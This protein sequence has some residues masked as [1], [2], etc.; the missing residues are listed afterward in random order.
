MKD[1]NEAYSLFERACNIDMGANLHSSNDGIHAGSIGGIW[2]CAVMGFGGL[3]LVGDK[4]RLEP[5]LPVA[6]HELTFFAWLH[7]QKV[8][9]EITKESISLKNLTRTGEVKLEING[10]EHVLTDVLNI[11][12]NF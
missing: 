4:I 10:I 9:V 7:G 1:Y 11:K 5:K 2:Q 8:K 6:W 12:G 3:R